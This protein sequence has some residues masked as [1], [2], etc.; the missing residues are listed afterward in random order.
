MP[1]AT[2]PGEIVVNGM[3]LSKRDSPFANAGTVVSVDASDIKLD[4]Q[5]NCPTIFADPQRLEQIFNNLLSNALR[6][7]PRGGSV[8]VDLKCSAN[9]VVISVRDN[10][11]GIPEHALAHVF[12]RFY[13]AD[14][15]RS[16]S[17][18]GTGLGLSIAKKLALSHGGDLTATN[19][20]A[21]GALFTLSLPVQ[22]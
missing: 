2:A 8:T 7:T 16:R 6:F 1:A 21:G 5:E 4:V 13:K 19:H 14:Y 10:G 17:N 11:P 20:P 18:G 3:S 15:S 22:S 9:Q 12:D